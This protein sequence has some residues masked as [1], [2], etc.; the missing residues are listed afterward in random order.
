M[1]ESIK[2][3]IRKSISDVSSDMWYFETNTPDGAIHTGCAKLR[4]MSECTAMAVI[5]HVKVDS[6]FQRKGVG[7]HIIES[8]VSV[9]QANGIRVLLA[10]IR[11]ENTA[12]RKLFEKHGFMGSEQWTSPQYG[13]RVVLYSKA[14]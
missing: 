4:R 11:A 14:L 9:A 2:T 10:T 7:S 1:S 8:I 6:L 5:F 3:R 13:G 12:S